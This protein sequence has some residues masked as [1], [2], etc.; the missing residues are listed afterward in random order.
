MELLLNNHHELPEYKLVPEDRRPEADMAIHESGGFASFHAMFLLKLIVVLPAFIMLYLVIMV[1]NPPRILIMILQQ[2]SLV[3]GAGITYV[4]ITKRS[5]TLALRRYLLSID[6]PICL[7]CGYDCRGSRSRCPECG[8]IVPVLPEPTSDDAKNA[9]H[10]KLAPW[11]LAVSVEGASFDDATTEPARWRRDQ[12]RRAALS[13]AVG[14]LIPYDHAVGT[15]GRGIALLSRLAEFVYGIGAIAGTKAG[16]PDIIERE[17]FVIV[18]A[19]WV[20]EEAVSEAALAKLCRN[21]FTPQLERDD[22]PMPIAQEVAKKAG[23]IVSGRV[24]DKLAESVANRIEAI[25]RRRA[26]AAWI[27]IYGAVVGAKVSARA[28]REIEAAAESWYRWKCGIV[29]SGR[30]A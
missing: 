15:F 18:I 11:I 13:G 6:I 24:S 5:H 1:L 16:A 29:L 10:N 19:N 26:R 2:I 3:V 9:L 27:P 7:S 20:G 22:D 25:V 28:M 17:D 23:L 12:N 8:A 4:W 14:G 21:D 30:A